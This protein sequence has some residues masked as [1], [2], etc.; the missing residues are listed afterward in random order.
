MV[1]IYDMP[2]FQNISY[3]LSKFSLHWLDNQNNMELGNRLLPIKYTISCVVP[4][5]FQS[6]FT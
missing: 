3:K 1:A 5:A 4:Y 2:L 6:V